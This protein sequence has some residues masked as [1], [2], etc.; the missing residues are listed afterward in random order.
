MKHEKA[1]TLLAASTLALAVAL[2]APFAAATNEAPKA[3]QSP[4]KK[5]SEASEQPYVHK[6]FVYRSTTAVRYNPLGLSTFFRLGYQRPLLGPQENIL[7]Q[8]TYIGLHAIT[9]LTPA[10]IRG[11]VR[12]DVQ[13]LAF[14]QFFFAYEG[15]QLF[16]TFDSLQS[17]QRVSEDWGDKAQTA[18]GKAGLSYPTRGGIFTAEAVLQAKVGPVFFMSDTQ[19]F[20]TDFSI[21]SGDRFYV[22]LPLSMLAKDNG[23]QVTNETDLLFVTSFGL[24]VGARHGIYHVFYPAK[25]IIGDEARAHQ[26]E[27]VEFAGPLLLY[28][29]KEYNGPKR[30]NA[31]TVFLN[32]NFWIKNPYRTGQE[33]AQTVPYVIAGFTFK[34]TL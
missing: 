31:P 11:G 16:G 3:P 4:A 18:R 22:D 13:P 5:T 33:V 6:G 9:S 21:K 29:V 34:G 30:F 2:H 25:D 17:F 10:F 15:M 8:R 26:I 24:S 12:L 14:L 20:H 32:L 1:Q 7:L 19:F 27:T 28:Q 23:W